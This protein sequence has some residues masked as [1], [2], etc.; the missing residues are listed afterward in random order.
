MISKTDY[1]QVVSQKLSD[2]LQLKSQLILLFDKVD[3]EGWGAV[4]ESQVK[5]M[6]LKILRQQIK[7]LSDD[8]DSDDDSLISMEV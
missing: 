3:Q 5:K 4:S 8:V 2:D 1:V 6:L 7:K